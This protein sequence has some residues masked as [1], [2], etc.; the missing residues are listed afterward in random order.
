MSSS[1]DF[2]GLGLS[3]PQS[4]ATMVGLGGGRFSIFALD[5]QIWDEIHEV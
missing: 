4:S 3:L 5:K 2:A 1:F